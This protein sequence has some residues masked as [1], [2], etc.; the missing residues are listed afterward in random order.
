MLRDA[1]AYEARLAGVEAAPVLLGSATLRRVVQG[2][3]VAASLRVPIT[4]PLEAQIDLVVDDG[5]NPPLDVRGVQAIF[6]DLP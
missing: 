4:P 6:D 1:S 2:S 5:D 3:L